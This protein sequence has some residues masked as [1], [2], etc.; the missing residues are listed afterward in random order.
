MSVVQ[1]VRKGRSARRGGGGQGEF[2]TASGRIYVYQFKELAIR[3][4]I[5]WSYDI[6]G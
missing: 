3:A 2:P 4:V 6:D 5:Y 1:P